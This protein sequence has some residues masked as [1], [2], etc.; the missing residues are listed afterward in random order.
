MQM[1]EKTVCAQRASRI[2]MRLSSVYRPNMG[3]ILGSCLSSVVSDAAGYRC[4]A[5]A[6]IHAQIMRL[7]HASRTPLISYPLSASSSLDAGHCDKRCRAPS[8]SLT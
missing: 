8:S 6:G 7:L 1:A 4:F 5:G 3:A 2:A